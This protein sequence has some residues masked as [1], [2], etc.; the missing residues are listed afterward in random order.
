MSQTTTEEVP[1]RVTSSCI[2]KYHKQ[3]Y[4]Q[5]E[6]IRLILKEKITRAPLWM[7]DLLKCDLKDS[8]RVP[9]INR[10]MF[11]SII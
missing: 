9:L 6:L 10:H 4:L 11:E 1:K 2:R 8:A 7:T 5:E 3:R